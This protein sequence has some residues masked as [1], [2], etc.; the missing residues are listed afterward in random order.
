MSKR[1]RRGRRYFYLPHRFGFSL[2]SGSGHGSYFLWFSHHFVCVWWCGRGLWSFFPW[3]LFDFL[4]LRPLL[5]FFVH[6]LVTEAV[7]QLGLNLNFPYALW[8][9]PTLDPYHGAL[10]LSGPD[11][12]LLFF[13]ID[14]EADFSSSNNNL[15]SRS[16]QERSPQVEWRFFC[17][18]HVKY[19]EVDADEVTP[20]FH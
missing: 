7:H 8:I 18:F 1:N 5:D 3:D 4:L 6:I 14:I 12:K 11:I 10:L 20:D 19:Y 17:G 9:W 15:C 2:W 13:T 16:A